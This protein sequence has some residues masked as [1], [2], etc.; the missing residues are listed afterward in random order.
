MEV[1]SCARLLETLNITITGVSSGWPDR[2]KDV[3]S[4]RCLRHFHTGNYVP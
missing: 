1:L 4:V 2:V 3:S